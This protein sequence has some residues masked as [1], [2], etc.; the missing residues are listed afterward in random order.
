MWWALQ[1]ALPGQVRLGWLQNGSDSLS[2]GRTEDEPCSAQS[3]LCDPV[4]LN[5]PEKR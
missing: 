2:R 3:W 4:G 5:L 1:V